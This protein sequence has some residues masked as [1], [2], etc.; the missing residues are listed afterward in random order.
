[1]ER[2]AGFPLLD[3]LLDLITNIRLGCKGLLGT[4]TL[5]YCKKFLN[6]DRKT[7]PNIGTRT[8]ASAP[9][10]AAIVALTLEANPSLTWR[11]VQHI[12]VRTAR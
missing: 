7:F 3:G 9:M 8:S 12:I 5:A 2:L 6:Y 4:S 10:A 11:D 1:M